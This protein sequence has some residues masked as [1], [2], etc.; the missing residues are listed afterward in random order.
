ME[1]EIVEDLVDSAKIVIKIDLN[2]FAK[3]D[4]V[5]SKKVK[6]SIEKALKIMLGQNAITEFN[7]NKFPTYDDKDNIHEEKELK[8]VVRSLLKTYLHR[9]Y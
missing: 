8:E 4:K 9:F 3:D 6:D 2:K 7:L 1:I 5:Q